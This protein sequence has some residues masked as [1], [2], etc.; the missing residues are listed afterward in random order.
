MERRREL[1]KLN[2]A[3]L[4]MELERLDRLKRLK[5]LFDRIQTLP[6][7]VIRSAMAN[8][9]VSTAVVQDSQIPSP[10]PKSAE[11]VRSPAEKSGLRANGNVPRFMQDE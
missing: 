11:T 10:L 9:H 5:P 3:R 6:P 2:E 4:V 8:L 1:R 7:V